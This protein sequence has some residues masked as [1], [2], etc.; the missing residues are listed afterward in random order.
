MKLHSQFNPNVVNPRLGIAAHH[1][2][3]HLPL[4]LVEPSPALVHSGKQRQG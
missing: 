2:P 4:L 1:F 3:F